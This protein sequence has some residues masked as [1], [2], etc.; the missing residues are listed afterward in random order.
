[1][2]NSFVFWVGVEWNLQMPV[3][4][5]HIWNVMNSDN[6]MNIVAQKSLELHVVQYIWNAKGVG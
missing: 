3:T 4:R 6:Q 1:M 2:A 5:I